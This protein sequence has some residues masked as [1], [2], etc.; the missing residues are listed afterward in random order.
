MKGTFT[1]HIVNTVQILFG[2]LLVIL[3]IA[4]EDFGIEL[5]TKLKNW[6]YILYLFGVVFF[7]CIIIKTVLKKK[8]GIEDPLIKQKAAK[9][10]IYISYG[11]F[12]LFF[13]VETDW[14]G[15][16]P[17]LALLAWLLQIAG[18]IISFFYKQ[19]G[20]EQ[21]DEIIDDQMISNEA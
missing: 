21:N 6:D 15:I 9:I 11:I 5:L 10:L 1:Q 8:F 20:N 7:S 18:L 19:P 2:G 12:F 17:A 14:Y 4:K 3:M 16:K 13:I